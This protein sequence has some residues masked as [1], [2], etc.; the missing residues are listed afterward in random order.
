M[1]FRRKKLQEALT[2]GATFKRTRE[3]N[4]TEFATVTWVGEGPFGIPH[5]RFQVIVP[6]HDDAAD[7]RILAVSAFIDSY[8]PTNVAAA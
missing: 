3:H 5:V 4:V 7:T 1:F 2:A 6:G 8:T